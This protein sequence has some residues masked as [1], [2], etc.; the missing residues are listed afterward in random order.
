VANHLHFPS[1]TQL[2]FFSLFSSSHLQTLLTSDCYFLFTATGASCTSNWSFYEQ[3]YCHWSTT[4]LIKM[5][6]CKKIIPPIPLNLVYSMEATCCSSKQSYSCSLIRNHIY[7]S[8]R[9][10]S[11]D[12]CSK[13]N[14]KNSSINR[15]IG[16]NIDSHQQCSWK[17][18]GS[19][20]MFSVFS[21]KERMAILDTTVHDAAL[22]K[23][24][25][26][27]PKSHPKSPKPKM[28]NKQPQTQMR[29]CSTKHP[30]RM[31]SLPTSQGCQQTYKNF[32][33]TLPLIANN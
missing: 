10:I 22:T 14:N 23:P 26:V 25:Q 21:H 1:K 29:F 13:Q 11:I 15:S 17:D 4:V 18:Q 12:I 7:S 28:T 24:L 20:T 6:M 9:S 31:L 27:S 2:L 32:P 19:V 8:H 30:Q 33:L 16:Q 5:T 3:H